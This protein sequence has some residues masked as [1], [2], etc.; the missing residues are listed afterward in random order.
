MPQIKQ[1]DYE[2]CP[3]CCSILSVWTIDRA[4][5]KVCTYCNFWIH[6]PTVGLASVGVIVRRNKVLLVKRNRD[7]HK[8]TWNLPAGFVEYREHPE[9]A[10]RREIKEETGLV[11][12]RARFINFIES[13]EDPRSPGHLV[14]FYYV[15]A[16]GK[17]RNND[18]NENKEVAWFDINN[19]PEI[20]WP[21]HQEILRLLKKKNR[22]ERGHK[23]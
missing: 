8:N 15:S 4:E 5:R 17:I 3:Y 16:T 7:P 14:F 2:Y 20:G 21:T 6:Y 22:K 23:R 9:A 18:P 11:V 1:S 12:T 19:L 10:L 13:D